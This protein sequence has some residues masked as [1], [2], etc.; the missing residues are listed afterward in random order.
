[1][2]EEK[3]ASEMS[4]PVATPTGETPSAE[5]KPEGPA[6]QASSDQDEFEKALEAFESG[7][8]G[9]AYDDTFRPL[10]KGETLRATVIH[11]DEDRAY[12]DLGMKQEGEIPKNELALGDVQNAN[13]VVKVGDEISVVVLKASRSA[14]QRPIVSKKAADFQRVWERLLE[15]Y[16]EGRTITAVVLERV[17]GGLLADVGVRG[18][19]PGSHVGTG[20][21]KNLDKYVGSTLKFKIIEVDEE[22]RKVVLSNRLALEEERAQKRKEVFS[23]LKA[24]DRVQ[25]VVRRVTDYGVFVDVGGADGLLHVSELDWYRVDD[26]HEVVKKG[27][28]IEV[29]VLKIDP[30][31]ERISLGRRQVLPDPW[32]E[33]PERYSRDQILKLPISRTVQS[34]AFVKLPEGVEAFIPL[35]ELSPQRIKRP[36]DA[37]EVGQ[38]YE[39]KIVDLRP[40][41]RR[42]VLSIRQCLPQEER[43]PRHAKPG[44]VHRTMAPPSATGGGTIGERLGALKG[45][46]VSQVGGDEEGAEGSSEKTESDGPV[47]SA[48]AP[49]TAEETA[50]EAVSETQDAE[51][52]TE[53]AE[54]AEATEGAEQ[55]PAE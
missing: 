41:E 28:K 37:V 42:M 38:E 16:R 18:F 27:Q 12:V 34:G 26:P 5:T 7:E 33:I 22:R 52:T 11:V 29:M 31:S 51:A 24:G 32:K 8:S 2:S 14:E 1:M 55:K 23:K 30:E 40:E 13:D 15:D 44:E 54:T 50:P 3:L 47:A 53:S 20:K 6:A 10:K 21:T 4:E 35:S 48:D 36:E 9:T 45:L 25:G 19:V 46:L 17:K 43:R 39:M 49:T